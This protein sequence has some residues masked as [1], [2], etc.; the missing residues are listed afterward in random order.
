MTFVAL[1]NE[2]CFR[3]SHFSFSILSGLGFTLLQYFTFPS[4]RA[5]DLRSFVTA[6]Q[7]EVAFGSRVIS[8]ECFLNFPEWTGRRRGLVIRRSQSSHSNNTRFYCSRPH[9]PRPQYGRHLSEGRNVNL[10]SDLLT[11]L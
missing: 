1:L 10:F 5:R 11:L 3:H 9:R 6:V 8:H 4:F 7:L 2:A